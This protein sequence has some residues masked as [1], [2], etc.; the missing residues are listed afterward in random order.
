MIPTLW[1][2]KLSIG[3]LLRSSTLRWLRFTTPTMPLYSF[4]A[5]KCSWL[6]SSPTSL[7]LIA[8]R[9]R[10]LPMFLSWVPDSSALFLC[11]CRLSLICDKDFVWWS[12]W[13]TN[14]STSQIQGV[15]SSSPSCRQLVVSPP[16]CAVSSTWD[17]LTQ[18]SMSSSSSSPLPPS[19]RSMT[20]MLALSQKMATRLRKRVHLWRWGFTN[21]T[22]Y[23]MPI[24]DSMQ[25]RTLLTMSLFLE[26]D[27]V[28]KSCEWIRKIEITWEK[29]ALFALLDVS[30]SKCSASSMVASSSTSCHTCL[31]SFPTSQSSCVWTKFQ[32]QQLQHHD[33]VC[34]HSRP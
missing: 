13:R 1:L 4:S 31:S 16:R 12:T 22:G 3:K 8:S 29:L 9:S 28:H 17:L 11:T 32:L 34:L 10:F 26:V 23:T 30:F 24:T 15:P 20:S 25:W 6:P 19:Q 5:S 21:V 14:H 33:R 18:L 27:K 7:P 2:S